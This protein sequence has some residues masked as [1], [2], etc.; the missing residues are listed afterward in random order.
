MNQSNPRNTKQNSNKLLSWKLCIFTLLFTSPISTEIK[1]EI[2]G[3][4]I[5]ARGLLVIEDLSDV[6]QIV[7]STSGLTFSR[8]KTE[9]EAT[10]LPEVNPA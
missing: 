8:K 3:F 10:D 2:G 9:K 5:L 7:K 1:A 6:S 4:A